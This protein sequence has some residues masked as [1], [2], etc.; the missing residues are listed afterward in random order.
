M[1]KFKYLMQIII[2][3]VSYIPVA[4]SGA[5]R[6]TS[7]EVY[8][9]KN[10]FFEFSIT[11]IIFYPNYI[12]LDFDN[13]NGKFFDAK[14]FLEIETSIDEKINNPYT[15]SYRELITQ[16]TSKQSSQK[17]D[18]SGWVNFKLD[19]IV[20]NSSSSI[21]FQGFHSVRN[22]FRYARHRLDMNFNRLDDSFIKCEGSMAIIVE[23]DI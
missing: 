9:Q 19:D 20:F 11:D 21:R 1:R 14:T 5:V 16:C 3:C 12:S 13:A 17:V 23:F 22:G 7:I 4:N 18:V 8:L 10:N 2:L 15:L 6:T